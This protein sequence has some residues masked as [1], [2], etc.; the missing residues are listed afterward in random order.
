MFLACEA[1]LVSLASLRPVVLVVEDVHWADPDTLD[2]LT[3]LSRAR[4]GEGVHLLVTCRQDETG[5]SGHVAAWLERTRQDAR[6]VEVRLGPLSRPDVTAL[7]DGLVGSGSSNALVDEVFTRGEGNPFFT[8][9][10]VASRDG[11]RPALVP[12]RLADFLTGRVRTVSADAQD[13]MRVLAVAGRPLPV[14]AV[15][16]VTGHTEE[17]CLE[18]VRELARASL[19]LTGPDGVRPRH[20]LLRE[21]LVEELA[22]VPRE[23]HRRLARA[24]ESLGD[25]SVDPEVAGHYRDAGDA[26]PELGASLRVA[27]RAWD[28]GAYREAAQWW[29][30]VIAL[31]EE[32]PSGAPDAPDAEQLDPATAYLHAIRSLDLSGQRLAAHDLAQRAYARFDSWPDLQAR[33]ALLAEVAHQTIIEHRARGEARYEELLDLFEDH[34][35]SAEQARALVRYGALRVIF[36]E[37]QQGEQLL[38]RGRAVA[39]AAAAD[40]ELAEALRWLAELRRAEGDP[41]AARGAART[42]QPRSPRGPA[43]R[44]RS[45]W[46]SPHGSRSW[47]TTGRG[48]RRTTT[49]SPRPTRLGTP[50][51]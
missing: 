36:G 37:P 3:F 35:A 31:Q 50:G 34:E 5:L 40:P 14:T 8:E 23:F 45:S 33:R 12:T 43:T 32:L 16:D 30:R 51:C 46:S 18:A 22:G 2:L 10:L 38:L 49:P 47:S 17:R 44:S 4:H 20:A 6:V 28:L 41:K 27:R 26:A 25:S 19:V 1:L 11:E 13:V 48:P 39:E 21:A 7:V 29:L 42:R 15:C 24:L 9:Q